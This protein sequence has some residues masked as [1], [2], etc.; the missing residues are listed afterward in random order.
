MIAVP[1]GTD[2]HAINIATGSES[3]VSGLPNPG[4]G[5]SYD[6]EGTFWFIGTGSSGTAVAIGRAEQPYRD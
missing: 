2:V 6:E 1:V 3:W 5:G 4:R